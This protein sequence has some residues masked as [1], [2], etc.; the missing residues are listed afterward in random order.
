MKGYSTDLRER[1]VSAL[2]NGKSQS[3]VAATFQVSISSVQR[4]I[5]RYRR[6]GTV[7]ATVQQ[8]MV[9]LIGEEDYP[10]LQALVARLPEAQLP[11]YCS[12]WAAETGIVVSPKTM[13]RVLV[14][15]G[16]R[17]KKD[18]RGEGAG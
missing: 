6:S 15:L 13:S 11:E 8:R 18:R 2:Q 12:A 4:W 17:R 16:L 10:V 7:V 3:W 5:E 14:R 1:V 9:G